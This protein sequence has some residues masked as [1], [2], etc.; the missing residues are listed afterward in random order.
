MSSYL[1]ISHVS[2]AIRSVLWDAIHDE[3]PINQFLQTEN[4]IVFTNPTETAQTGENRLSIWLHH[5]TENA[6][7]KNHPARIRDTRDEIEPP[8]LALNLFYLITPFAPNSREPTAEH[9]MLGRVMQVFH[10]NAILPVIDHTENEEAAEDLRVILCRMTLEELTRIW[11]ALREPY[12][13][14]ICYEVRVIHI[15][16]RRRAGHEPVTE[17]LAG[18]TD[19][20]QQLRRKDL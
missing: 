13:L 6:F 2:E 12:R 19:D 3:D 8:P 10:D 4:D 9:M 11:E 17:R 18:Y 14:S 16:S 5:I 1:V 15:D 20:P 7:E